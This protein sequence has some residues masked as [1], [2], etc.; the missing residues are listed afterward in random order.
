[1]MNYLVIGNGIDRQVDLLGVMF[2]A[3]IPSLKH[4]A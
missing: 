1:L 4:R 2:S 3:T